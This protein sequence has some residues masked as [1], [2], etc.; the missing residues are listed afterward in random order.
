MLIC[1]DLKNDTWITSSARQQVN[2]SMNGKTLALSRCYFSGEQLQNVPTCLLKRVIFIRRVVQ[3]SVISLDLVSCLA[4]EA[5][6]GCA[7]VSGE[8]RRTWERTQRRRQH[9][10]G[11]RS[12]TIS[13][14]PPCLA[15]L[16]TSHLSPHTVSSTC[17]QPRCAID[18]PANVCPI[19]SLYFVPSPSDVWWESGGNHIHPEQP[20]CTP[21]AR[22]GIWIWHCLKT[23]LCFW[24]PP[25]FFTVVITF[26]SST[27]GG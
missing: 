7:F 8:S 13:I 22:P 10:S 23:Y 20:L 18:S 19:L 6:A 14:S 16:P 12:P 15:P 26:C 21:S 17:P 9:R 3:V 11:S 27:L 2:G 25:P 24:I 5:F 1:L 4:A